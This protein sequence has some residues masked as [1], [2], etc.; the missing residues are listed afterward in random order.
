MGGGKSRPSFSSLAKRSD[1]GEVA[2]RAEHDVTEGAQGH[3]A[4]L[5][6]TGAKVKTGG[7][8]SV[9]VHLTLT[10]WPIFSVPA[11]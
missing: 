8:P 7:P 3:R 9:G 2:R 1:A 5:L 4:D 6:Q 10:L 11:S